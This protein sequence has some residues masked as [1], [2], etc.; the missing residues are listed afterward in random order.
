MVNGAA[1]TRPCPA[2]EAQ[3]PR[4][5]RYCSACGTAI[6]PIVTTSR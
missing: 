3:T 6:A 4:D 5:A 1:A 2:C